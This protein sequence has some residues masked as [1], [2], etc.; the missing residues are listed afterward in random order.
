[1]HIHCLLGLWSILELHKGTKG[2]LGGSVLG[3]LLR[4]PLPF[5]HLTVHLKKYKEK[6]VITSFQT[7]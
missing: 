6:L 5:K 2:S 7:L 3:Q 4:A 1:V